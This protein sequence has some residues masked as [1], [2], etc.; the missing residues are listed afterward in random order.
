MDEYSINIKYKGIKGWLLLLCIS[1]T[2]LDPA[3]M[4]LNLFIMSNLAKPFFE[5]H[6]NLFN[7]IL[8]NGIFTTGLMVFSIYAG[9][10]LWRLAVNAV[11][12]AKRYFKA[13]FIYSGVTIFLPDIFGV[14]DNLYKK[15]G[16][17]NLLN[18]LITMCY[19]II[20]YLYLTKSK[21]VRWTYNQQ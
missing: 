15:F 14:S 4:L 16:G 8:A 9:L 18:S 6:R 12:T 20:W 2:I 17:N 7:L 21:R 11:V 3:T 13:I 10:S 1:L 19:A 5:T